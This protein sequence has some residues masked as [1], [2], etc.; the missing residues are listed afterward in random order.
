MNYVKVKLDDH[1]IEL[2]RN[3][4]GQ[5]MHRFIRGLTPVNSW[6]YGSVS[7]VCDQNI[8]QVDNELQVLTID[9]P[10]EYG[11]LTVREINN[12]KEIDVLYPLPVETK[13]E[14]E[15]IDVKI[16]TDT[17][18]CYH[19]QVGI[20]EVKFDIALIF[21][22]RSS[23]IIFEKDVWFDED[24]LV[25]LNCKSENVLKP[26]HNGWTFSEPYRGVYSREIK[27]VKTY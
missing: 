6:T 10:E 18:S 15:I 24:N 4:I 25:H 22:L 5:K 7:V 3:L 20:Y 11:V 21:D 14:S 2:L 12:K 1:M 23:S 27:S 26:I 13:V 9:F 16:V 8:I 17:I 19:G